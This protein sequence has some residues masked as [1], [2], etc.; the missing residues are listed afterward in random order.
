MKL[1]HGH[2]YSITSMERGERGRTD[3]TYTSEILRHKRVGLVHLSVALSKESR[4][5]DELSLCNAQFN[6]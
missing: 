2:T 4:V 1:T 6:Y 5:R 3:L